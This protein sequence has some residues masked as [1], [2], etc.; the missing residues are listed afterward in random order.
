MNKPIFFSNHAL[1]RMTEFKL[2]KSAVILMIQQGTKE[3]IKNM[4]WKK[5]KYHGNEGVTYIRYDYYII[6]LAETKDKRTNDPAYCVITVTD[7]R[8]HIR[9]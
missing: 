5:E 9:A 2:T 6:T 3:K 1:E 8:I 4:A 7:Q